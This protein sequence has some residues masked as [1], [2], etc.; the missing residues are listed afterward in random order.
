MVYF[1]Y[2][3]KAGKIQL[4]K[5]APPPPEL[6]EYGKIKP[7]DV[8]FIGRTNYVAALEE[9]RYIFG[10]KRE[11]RKRH[12]YIIGKSGVGKSKLQELMVRQDIAYGYG[13]C[14]VDPHGEL[15]ESILDFIPENRI[16]DVCI[17]DPGDIN[18][19]VAFNP[20]L[21]I[22][23]TFKHQFTQ[24]LVERLQK[25]FGS[26]WSPRLE[27]VFRFTILALLDY[28]EATMEGMILMLTESSYRQ[29]V[30]EQITDDM[31]K[32]FWMHEFNEW[33]QK[34][35]SDAIIP[36]VGKL[37]QFVSDPML[38][39]IF[40]QS[41]NKI[42]LEK[43]MNNQK[44]ILV[45]LAK[46]KIGDEKASFFGAL[47]LLKLKQ[48]GMARADLDKTLRQDFYLYMDEFQNVVTDTFENMLSESKKYGISLTL[49]HQYI[50]Q[51]VPKVQQA[52][53]NHVGS[54]IAFRLGG[55]DALKFKPEFAPVFDTK[56]LI[57]LGVA[58]FYIKMT[59]DGESYDPFSAETLKVL[60]PTHPSYRDRIVDASRD[61]F[62]GVLN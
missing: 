46:G 36:L 18:F 20:L 4:I 53:L 48:A 13:V 35:D 61:E 11:D 39:G 29:K 24:G 55:D 57:N 7:E 52:V 60:A 62:A 45:N 59:I 33:A 16:N 21:G 12:L 43:L 51:L 40:G 17:I 50:A 23:P 27:H 2:M 49:A 56:D 37:G 3:A 41:Q 38:R 10:I 47:F 6:P 5:Y 58:E 26:T 19:P 31:V 15:I 25:Q 28:P 14:V 32:R 1:S 42:D 34:F 54:I 22:K 30:I 9:K 8:S 44:I